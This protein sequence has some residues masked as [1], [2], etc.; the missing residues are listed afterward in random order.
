MRW[1]RAGFRSYWR[2]GSPG[3][4]RAV[5]GVGRNSPVDPRNEHCEP[6]MGSAAVH[7][8]LLKIGID[9]GQTSVAKYMV[10]RREP[11]SHGWKTFLDN[12]AD[13]IAAMDLFV[14]PTV[15]F[16]LLYGLLIMGHSRG[17]ILWIGVTAHPTAE[18]LANQ[19]TQAFGWERPLN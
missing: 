8:E 18:W 1:N 7:G 11:P 19:L 3:V 2:A 9:V 6:V 15:S 10:R 5:P 16:Q 4:A 12:H 13:G 14:V 17:Q